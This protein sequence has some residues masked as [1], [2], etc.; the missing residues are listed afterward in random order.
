MSFLPLCAV[1]NTLGPLPSYVQIMTLVVIYGVYF[2]M[3][4]LIGRGLVILLNHSKSLAQ[5]W[6]R[7]Y[8]TEL[9][10]T[11]KIV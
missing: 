3:L 9:H 11:P 7:V 8:F 5:C 4:V 10:L 1:G 6:F 2:V